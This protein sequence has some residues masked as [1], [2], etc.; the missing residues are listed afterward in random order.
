MNAPSIVV[1]DDSLTVRKIVEI[2]LCR[3]GY[4][5]TSFADPVSGLR[6]LLDARETSPPGL[7][8]ADIGLPHLD[9][10]LVE[11]ARPHRDASG[12]AL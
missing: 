4:Q 6:T 5:V 12:L 3:V 11:R 9:G 1:I 10:Y 8:I 2:C 7:L